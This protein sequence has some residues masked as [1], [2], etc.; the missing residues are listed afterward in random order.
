MMH[1]FRRFPFWGGAVFG[2]TVVVIATLMLVWILEVNL[3]LGLEGKF[4]QVTDR[5]AT[6][7]VPIGAAVI[8]Y[9]GIMKQVRLQH[10]LSERANAIATVIGCFRDAEMAESEFK[11]KDNPRPK[12]K[13]REWEALEFAVQRAQLYV[14]DDGFKKLEGLINEE[15]RGPDNDQF[16]RELWADM[17]AEV[18]R[19]NQ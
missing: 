17:R 15:K 13:T 10:L 8:A 5:T 4:Y 6:V 12:G 7:L 16:L 1:G 18:R 9:L 14:S 2:A 19:P 3:C 11:R